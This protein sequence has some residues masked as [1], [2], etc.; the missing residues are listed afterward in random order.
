MNIELL[1]P[2]IAPAAVLTFTDMDGDHITITDL[3]NSL[4]QV[5]SRARQRALPSRLRGKIGDVHLY[6]PVPACYAP[7]MRA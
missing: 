7:A 1:E 6:A 4:D 2:R 5:A 3:G